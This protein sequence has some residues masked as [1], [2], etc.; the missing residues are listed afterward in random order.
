MNKLKT[1]RW[2]LPALA[3]A[4][5]AAGCGGGGSDDD[6]SGGQLRLV[7]GTTDYASLDLYAGDTLKSQDTA[8]FAAGGYVKLDAATYVMALKRN[9]STTTASSSSRTVSAGG[10]YT[11]LAYSTESSLRMAYL[12]DGEAAPAA[13]KAK[14]RVLNA[15]VEAGVLDTYIF[16]TDGVLADQTPSV[17]NLATE[18]L[19]GYKEYAK[20]NY[21]VVVT[22]QGSKT[23]VRLD[24]PTIALSDQ[25]I[26]TLVVTATPGGVLVHGM[27]MNQRGEVVAQKNASARLRLVAG[28]TANGTV[29]A[30]ANGVTLSAGLASPA[31]VP[32]ALVPAGALTGEV[33]VNGGAAM[34]LPAFTAQPG[35]DL[36]LLVAGTP[37]APASYVLQDNNK[38]ASNGNAKLRVAHGVNGLAGNLALTA[39]YGM[40]ASDIPFGSVSVAGS[41]A[42][43][44]AYRLEV[45]SPAAASRLYLN[46]EASLQSSRIYTVFMLGDA[47]APVGTLVRDR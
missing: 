41:L 12:S 24:L 18:S 21:R 2:L 34:P 17:S 47:A 7:N 31:I 16:Q 32:Y 8:S 43:G 14:L 30:K 26:V 19:S 11:L 39:D 45:T 46:T 29:S 35:A 4:L 3:A 27:L 6:D 23:D 1:L 10:T 25:Q 15:A 40:V 44:N 5:L 13:G 20:G 22:A 38:P 42:T 36:T 9:G 33:R 28:T 37:V